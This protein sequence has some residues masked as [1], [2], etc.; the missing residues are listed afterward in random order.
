[1]T[2]IVPAYGRDYMSKQAFV[3]DLKANKDFR[4]LDVSHRYNGK[5][6]TLDEL[7]GAGETQVKIRYN[8][9]QRQAV[10]DL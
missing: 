4:I 3:K 1:M 10:V 2:Q 7:K 9:L 8:K 5:Y 6:V